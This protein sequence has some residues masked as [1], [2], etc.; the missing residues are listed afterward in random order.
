MHACEL[1]VPGLHP[2]SDLDIRAGGGG[3]PCPRVDQHGAAMQ[4][5]CAGLIQEFAC[6]RYE[7]EAPGH[8]V[9]PICLHDQRQWGLGKADNLASEK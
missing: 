5:M 2:S 6:N 3:K 9:L 1:P 7:V 4:I 8:T